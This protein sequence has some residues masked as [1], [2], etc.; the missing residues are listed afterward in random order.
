MKYFRKCVQKLSTEF[1]TLNEQGDT[2][3]VYYGG[4]NLIYKMTLAEVTK[5]NLPALRLLST[6]NKS[7]KRIIFSNGA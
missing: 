2:L 6:K 5:T 7:T 4:S 1:V 3:S